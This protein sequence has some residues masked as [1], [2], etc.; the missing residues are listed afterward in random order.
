MFVVLLL[1][2]AILPTASGLNEGTNADHDHYTVEQGD[3]DDGDPRTHPGGHEACDGKDNDCDGEIDEDVLQTWYEDRDDDGFGSGVETEAGCEPLDGWVGV[4]GDCDDA[5]S[6]VFPGGV[7]ACDGHDNDCDA[8]VDE[9]DRSVWYGDADG[10]GYGD[11]A[12][13]TEVCFT[14]IGFVT[15]DRDC[16]DADAAIHPDASETCNERDDDCDAVVDEDVQRLY[17]LDADGDG[18]GVPET[19]TGCTVPQGY[20]YAPD[21]CNDENAEI[22][23]SALES[24]NGDDDDCDIVVDEGAADA[25]TWYADADGDGY[26]DAMFSLDACDQPVGFVLPADDCDDARADSHPG[27]VETCNTMD[28]DCDGVADDGC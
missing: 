20:A 19:T 1:A 9:D 7:E 11:A 26:G 12:V 14:P 5:D 15:D 16:D 6:D 18:H 23:P 8:L 22:S 10:D 28:D 4:R 27:A 2:C 17:F 24:C 13:V 21:D 25:P 3:C